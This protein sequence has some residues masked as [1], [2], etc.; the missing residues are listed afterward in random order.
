[1]KNPIS[2]NNSGSKSQFKETPKKGSLVN[3]SG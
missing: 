1:M 3:L 2:N